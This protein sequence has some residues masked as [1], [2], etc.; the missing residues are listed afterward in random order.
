VVSIASGEDVAEIR[1]VVYDGEAHRLV[2]F[3]LNKRGMFAGRLR[4]VL[5]T[6]SM[7]AIGPDAV[8]ID[9]ESAIDDS[10]ER[11]SGLDHL[12]AARPVIG[13]RVLS[14]DGDDLGEVVAVI[15]S[16]GAEPCAVGYE[17]QSSDRKD[18]SFVPIS[19]QMAL[20]GENLVLPGA[21]TDFVRNDLAGFGAAVAAYR[22][23]E[24]EDE[25]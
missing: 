20:S 23:P 1:D 18:T 3:T 17:L 7:T 16:T 5:T 13:N 11:P 24:L 15:M 14:A 12:D 6:E 8:M 25:R 21:A 4:A 22:T 2:G 10:D 9:A 19:A